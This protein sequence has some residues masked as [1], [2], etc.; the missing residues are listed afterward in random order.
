MKKINIY[1]IISVILIAF[2]TGCSEEFLER[3]PLD[4]EVSSNFYQTEEDA[5]Q[6]LVAVYDV[7][8]FQSSPNVSWAPLVTMADILSDDSYAG[9]SDANDGMDENELNTFNIPTT[10]K[11]VHAIYIKNYNGIYRANLLLE[12]IEDI[13]VSEEFKIRT[14]AECKFLR[15][16]FYFE[17]VRFFENIPLL[18][19][20]I[21]G[22]SEYSQTQNTPTEV[23]NQIAA[24]LVDAIN[25]LPES[26]PTNESGRVTKWA[27]EALLARVYLF[28]NGVYKTDL[29]ANGT[30]IDKAEVLLYLEDLIT[31]STHDLFENYET[32]FKLAGEFGE[33]SVFEISHGDSYAW[34]DWDFVRGGDGN[35]SAQ[36]QGPR[37]SGSENWNRGW[38]FGTV[39]QKLVDDLQGDPRLYK[40]V[41]FEDSLDGD[42]VP[43]YQHTGYFSKKYSSDAEHQSADG[44]LELNR[45]CN[46]RVIRYSDVLLMA[47]ELGSANAQQY[48]DKVR[49]RVGLASVSA[50]IDNIL[51]ERRLELSLEGIRY[52]DL[53]RQGM[54]VASQE[55][56]VGIYGS[57]YIGDQVL[58][59]VTFDAVTK[60]FLPIPQTEIDLSGG[61]FVQNEG[62]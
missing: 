56:T 10:N 32:N 15:A 21:K 42:L 20:T 18:T 37:V 5:M 9:G 46:H 25:D 19:E 55:L 51:N 38:S 4:R 33:E 44:Q 49:A 3:Y 17:Q 48:L 22:P 60:G 11:I 30:T 52:F 1:I 35:L 16:Y 54:N 28:Y 12:K 31:N 23:Y 40:T 62:Y 43:G 59:D 14:I 6:A 58:F 26:I 41:L 2:S 29:D 50:T 57:Q 34:W 61:L 47:A 8:G 7:L 36:M 45:T 24:D 13:V 39:S 53:I 27:A